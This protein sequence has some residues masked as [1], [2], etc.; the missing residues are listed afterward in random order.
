MKNLY[1]DFDGVIC[2][3]ID[4]TYKMI[5]E[6]NIDLK[7]QDKVVDFYRNLNWEKVLNESSLINDSILRIQKIIDSGKFNVSIL[8]HVN[9]DKE[10]AYKEKYIRKY[11]KNMPVIG[12]PKTLSK[13]EMVSATDS[14]L[15][16]DFVP[17]LI[18]W[19]KA[20]GH[21]IRFDLDMDGKGFPVIDKL[22]EIIEVF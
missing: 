22:D 6:L 10:I 20:G 4:I 12:V 3:T 8:T 16:D 5:N 11:F 21:G 2:N 13:T 7:D 15:I 14:I 9:S 1:V 19:R 17:N 18:D